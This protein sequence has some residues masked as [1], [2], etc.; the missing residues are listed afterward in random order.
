MR[1]VVY[2]QFRKELHIIKATLC[3]SSLRKFFIHASRDDM[4][5][6]R[7][8]VIQQWQICHCWWYTIAF[9]MD[10]K[11]LVPKNEDFLVETVGIE[12]AS[13]S[14]LLRKFPR[15]YVHRAPLKRTA[16]DG[17]GDVEMYWDA[18]MWSKWNIALQYEIQAS[19]DEIFGYAS[20]EIKFV[21]TFAKQIF[22]TL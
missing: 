21:I 12:G 2:Y 7:T 5:S 17:R 8:D 19:L 13:P 20:D 11:I 15:F 10:K 6:W 1:S 18:L 3:I 9:A 22:H 4:Q 14:H 16:R